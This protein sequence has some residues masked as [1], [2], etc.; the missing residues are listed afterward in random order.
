[1]EGYWAAVSSDPGQQP[2]VDANSVQI[3]CDYSN[4]KRIADDA[5]SCTEIQAYTQIAAIRAE[6]QTYHIVSWSPEELVATDVERGLSGG[7]TT[8]LLIHPNENEVEVIDRTKMDDKQPKLLDGMA[9]K[10]FGDHYELHGGMY[11]FDT[12]GVLF[13]C[14]EAGVVTDMR[15]D[16]AKKYHGDVVNVPSSEWNAAP[17]ADHKFTQHECEAALEKKLDDLR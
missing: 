5:N 9:G 14:D 15:L 11:L 1:M 4:S 3:D 16:V 7:T 8:T 2:V 13:Q 17:K 12:E 6:N 10:S